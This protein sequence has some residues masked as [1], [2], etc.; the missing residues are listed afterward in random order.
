MQLATMAFFIQ[1]KQRKKQSLGKKL[2]SEA[3]CAGEPNG[4]LD[5]SSHDTINVVDEREFTRSR[6]TAITINVDQRRYGRFRIL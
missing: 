1:W 6:H 3:V 2:A 5:G 4:T